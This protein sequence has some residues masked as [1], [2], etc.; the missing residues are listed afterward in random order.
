MSQRYLCIPLVTV[1]ELSLPADPQVSQR[2]NFTEPKVQ[3]LPTPWVDLSA[4][5]RLGLPHLP[6]LTASQPAVKG[7]P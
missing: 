5:L 6:P 7:Q 1:E 2:D 3:G 4:E